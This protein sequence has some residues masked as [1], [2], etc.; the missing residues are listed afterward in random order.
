MVMII[1][2]GPNSNS[3]FRYRVI[4]SSWQGLTL[5]SEVEEW[6]REA[7]IVCTVIPGSVYFKSEADALLFVL[8]WS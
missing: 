6:A 7:N 2:A 1:D 8:R 3:L 4:T 5:V